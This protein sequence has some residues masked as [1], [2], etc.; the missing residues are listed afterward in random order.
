MTFPYFPFSSLPGTEPLVI[1]R[2]VPNVSEGTR[3][4]NLGG[5]GKRQD[6]HAFPLRCPLASISKNAPP[7]RLPRPSTEGLAMTPP[8]CHCEEPGDDAISEEGGN[9]GIATPSTRNDREKETRH[10]T[11]FSSLPGTHPLVIARIVPNVGE[12]TR[13]RNLQEYPT[14]GIATSFYRRTRN[15]M[16]KKGPTMIP[17]FRLCEEP[18][19]EA[20]SEEGG[21]G[22]TATPSPFAAPWL[23]S[24]GMPHH[25]DCHVLLPKDS[26]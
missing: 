12:G 16:G 5:E 2:L 20:I 4:R 25:R 8:F 10:D 23:Q 22:S 13:R 14:T 6:Y 18:G 26:Q 9:G 1:A 21:N 24:P 15:D 3:R 11:P 19:D 17:S 7:P